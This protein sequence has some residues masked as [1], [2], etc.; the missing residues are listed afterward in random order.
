MIPCPPPTPRR[1]AGRAGPSNH[2]A[3]R[4]IS[5]TLWCLALAAS[6]GS[7]SVLCLGKLGQSLV[8]CQ[9]L[10]IYPLTP[11]RLWVFEFEQ[12]LW[13]ETRWS[14]LNCI[15]KG[16]FVMKIKL[17][18]RRPAT[19]SQTW[20]TVQYKLLLA[21]HVFLTAASSL[22]PL[23][24]DSAAASPGS[25]FGSHLAPSAS[26]FHVRVVSSHCAARPLAACAI[27][28]A[29]NVILWVSA[30]ES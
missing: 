27:I 18:S 11:Q 26:V 6:W 10:L 1:A 16:L 21:L 14:I 22:S 2:R 8:W 7:L 19:S 12:R 17:L 20:P 23:Q 15:L 30:R 29:Q 4:V 24:P 13:N 9:G 3:L 5:E 25:G 28:F